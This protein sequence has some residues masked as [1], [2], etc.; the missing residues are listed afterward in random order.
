MLHKKPK[1]SI[2]SFLKQTPFFAFF[3]VALVFLGAGCGV[4]KPLKQQPQEE[5]PTIIK[6]PRAEDIIDSAISHCHARGYVSVF[7]FN[8]EKEENDTYCAFNTFVGCDAIG[9]YQG[10]CTPSSSMKLPEGIVVDNIRTCPKEEVLVCGTDGFTYTNAC[11]AGLQHVPILHEDACTPEETER[12]TAQALAAA[13]GGPPAAGNSA[14]Q[15]TAT[16]RPPGAR[17]IAPAAAVHVTLT[18]WIDTLIALLPERGTAGNAALIEECRI[19]SNTYVYMQE[20]CPNCFSTLYNHEG[21]VQCFPHNDIK[22]NC[23]LDF[24]VDQRRSCSTIWTNT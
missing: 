18:G 23:P 20:K 17:R 4:D 14:E 7:H 3:A 15:S 1:N 12:L 22:E 24:I 8:E 21:V 10:T 6:N 9:Y 13:Q 2:Y 11:I 5:R 16:S 19:G